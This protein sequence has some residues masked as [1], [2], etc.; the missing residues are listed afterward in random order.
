MRTSFKG[1]CAYIVGGSSGIGLATAE[2]LV[3]Q[4]AN[5]VLLARRPDALDAAAQAIRQVRR[6]SDQ[7]VHAYTLDATDLD[8]CRRV[9]R[10]AIEENGPPDL[11]MNS[12]GISHPHYFEDVT[13]EQFDEVLKVNLYATFNAAHVLVPHMR[14][15]GG[16]ILNVSSVAGLVGVFGFT[17]YSA[18]KFAVIGFS[19]A[20]RAELKRFGITVSVLCPPDTDTPMLYRED[21]TKPVETKAIS[22][23]ARV[24]SADA[25]ARAALKGVYRGNFLIVPGMDAKASLWAKRL[26]PGVVEL[27]LDR[28]AQNA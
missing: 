7:R 22:K 20:L 4:G 5:V 18:A 26:V 2:R 25:V 19:E 16:A 23:G 1:K 9:F 10:L 24:M 11:L 6:R 21:R 12:A 3:V 15:R 8:A 13:P 17:S 27:V 14:D 28:M